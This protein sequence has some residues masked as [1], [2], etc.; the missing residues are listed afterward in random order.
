MSVEIKNILGLAQELDKKSIDFLSTAISKSSGKGFD[1]IKFKHSLNEMAKLGHSEETAFKS[2]FV[3]AATIGVTKSALVNSAK[4]YLSVLMNE[5]SQFDSALNNQVTQRVASKKEEVIK[6]QQR[7]E[8]Y[9]AKITEMEKRIAEYQGKID[10][11]DDEV[12]K[13]KKKIQNTKNKFE[14]TFNA[15]V[16]IIE[17]DVELMKQYL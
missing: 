6:L 10:S 5:K 14:K 15:F 16:S 9:K 3:T 8:E 11:A 4:K 2:A 13:A 17:S 12:Q 7:I 1:Y